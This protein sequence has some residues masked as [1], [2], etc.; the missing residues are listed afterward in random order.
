MLNIREL[1]LGMILKI[2]LS[3]FLISVGACFVILMNLMNISWWSQDF[4]FVAALFFAAVFGYII[5]KIILLNLLARIANS[6]GGED[7]PKAYNAKRNI[8][9][10]L[11][12]LKNP[13]FIYFVVATVVVVLIGIMSDGSGPYTGGDNEYIWKPS[14]R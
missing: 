5:F 9:L 8:G 14:R 11:D 7:K 6:F 1:S 12:F 10:E 2:F 13:A 4:W 3:I